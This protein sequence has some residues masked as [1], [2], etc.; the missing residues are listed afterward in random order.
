MVYFLGIGPGDPG[1]VT[2]KAAAIMRAADLIFVP[3][4]NYEGRSVAEAIIAPHAPADR[5]RYMVVP[6]TRD[7][8]V[9]RR[10]YAAI[11]DAIEEE[12]RAGKEVACVTLGDS[13]LYSTA[14]HI[15]ERLAER[16]IAHEYVA[17]IPSFVEA[18]NRF[19]FCLALGRE[20]TLTTPMPET[21]EEVEALVKTHDTVVFMKINKRLPVLL[22]YVRRH[23][24][25]RAVLACR[26]GLPDEKMIDLTGDAPPE[27]VGYLSLAL[28]GQQGPGEPS[29]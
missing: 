18:A 27:E 13:M 23:G 29:P 22:D 6:M 7:R 8:E 24:P 25:A 4:S 5:I 26:M 20:N 9:L 17:G 11:A 12:S 21:V 14:E 1:L 2:I 15:G 3:Q 28:I 10:V 16:A 19:G